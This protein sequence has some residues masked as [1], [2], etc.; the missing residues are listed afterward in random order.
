MK[1]IPVGIKTQQI[2]TNVPQYQITISGAE[3]MDGAPDS[4]D[5]ANL[6]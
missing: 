3:G 1:I 4:V 6:R 5:E 2:I